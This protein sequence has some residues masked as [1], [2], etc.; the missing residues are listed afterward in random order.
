M[1][2]TKEKIQHIAKLARLELTEKE[3]EEYGDQLSGILDYIK[4][5]K[6]VDTTN[7]KPTAQITDVSN[8]MRED[9]AE[10]WDEQ[11]IKKALEQAPEILDNQYK[12]KRIL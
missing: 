5:L 2:L 6:E 8:V 12:V 9:V 10:K 1:K 7:V 4:Q 3:M 11:E